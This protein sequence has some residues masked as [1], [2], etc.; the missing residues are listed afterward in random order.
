MQVVMNLQA[1]LSR[2]QHNASNSQPMVVEPNVMPPVTDPTNAE[3]SRN[4][5]VQVEADPRDTKH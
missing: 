4:Q 5:R 1:E 3:L 2:V